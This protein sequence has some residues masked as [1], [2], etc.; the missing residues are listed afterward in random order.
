MINFFVPIHNSVHCQLRILSHILPVIWMWYPWAVFPEQFTVKAHQALFGGVRRGWGRGG[1]II[2]VY[3][4]HTHSYHTQTMQKK[5]WKTPNL[6]GSP[7]LIAKIKVKCRKNTIDTISS[8]ICNFRAQK[9]R[10]TTKLYSFSMITFF[11]F[12]RTTCRRK[13]W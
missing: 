7:G 4:W 11:G 10:K 9:P 5:R 6:N 8:N 1:T 3:N 13:Y 2:P 12:N